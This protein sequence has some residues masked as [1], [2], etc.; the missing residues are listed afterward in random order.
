MWLHICITLSTRGRVHEGVSAVGLWRNSVA[1]EARRLCRE[2]ANKATA[3]KLARRNRQ[4]GLRA[5]S[6]TLAFSRL[7]A[8]GRAE[9]SPLCLQ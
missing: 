3:A 2:G 4:A 9:S 1:A 7:R 5:L 8:N 6:S